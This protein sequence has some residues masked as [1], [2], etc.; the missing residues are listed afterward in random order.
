MLAELQMYED[1]FQAP[2]LTQSSEFYDGQGK[3]YI[4]Q[5]E[6]SRIHTSHISPTC[7]QW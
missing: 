5:C 6:V 1:H 7:V 2:F 4:E 3:L